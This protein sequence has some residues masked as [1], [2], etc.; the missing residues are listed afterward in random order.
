M[1]AHY[2]AFGSNMCLDTKLNHQGLNPIASSPPI[3]R[4]Y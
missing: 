3:L 2:F 1:V 4:N